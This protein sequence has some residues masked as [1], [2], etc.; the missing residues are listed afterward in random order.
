MVNTIHRWDPEKVLGD[1]KRNPSILIV[2]ARGSGKSVALRSLFEDRVEAYDRVF[3]VSRSA[4]TLEWYEEWLPC[5]DGAPEPFVLLDNRPSFLKALVTSLGS[6][7]AGKRGRTLVLLDDVIEQGRT[8]YN[9]GLSSL[10]THGR[11]FGITVVM[12]TQSLSE[13]ST[14]IRKN[15][16]VK[17]VGS[18]TNGSEIEGVCSEFLSWCLSPNPDEW[19]ELKGERG[20]G[21]ITPKPT[22]QKKYLLALFRSCTVF[23]QYG[24][25]VI[26][27]TERALFDEAVSW[28]KAPKSFVTGVARERSLKTSDLELDFEGPST[29]VDD[30]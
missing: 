29:K 1:K 12:V 27:S 4:P 20:K 25:I 9:T 23:R 30:V 10:Y 18:L 28:Y 21:Y 14:A 26:D 2:A 19:P 6:V 17:L 15:S 24:F 13:V 16:E 5:R 22:H 11:H 3:V 8:R 7:E